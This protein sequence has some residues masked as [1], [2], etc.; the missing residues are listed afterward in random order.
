MND[1]TLDDWITK[2]YRH[3]RLGGR[4]ADYEKRIRASHKADLAKYGNDC[5]SR[6]E[7]VTG[8]AVWYPRNPFEF[9]HVN[10]LSLLDGVPQ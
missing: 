2:Y 5:I 1:M 4:G 3:D 6:H 9:K 7:S 10:Q 8:E